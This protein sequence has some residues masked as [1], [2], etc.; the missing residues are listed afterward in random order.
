MAQKTILVIDDE[1]ELL[2]MIATVL[3]AEKY[4]V[5]TATHGEE[6]LRVAR[7][8]QPDLIILDIMMPEMDG[9]VVCRQLREHRRTKEIPIVML[10]AKTSSIDQQMGIRVIGVQDYL[11]KPFDPAELVRRIGAVLAATSN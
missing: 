7:K 9:W 10:T 5:L 8:D 3:K 4:R 6:G 11:T 1:P 2:A